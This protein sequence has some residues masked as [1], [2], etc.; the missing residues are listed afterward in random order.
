MPHHPKSPPVFPYSCASSWGEDQYGLWMSLDYYA[1]Q[2][3]FRWIEPGTFM[4]GSPD[5]EKG[6]Y[7]DEEHHEVTLSQGFWMAETTVTQALWDSVMES[8]PSHFKGE[9]LPVETV[10]WDDC[11]AFIKKMNEH[12]PELEIRLPWE[13]EW[14]Y[15]CRAGTETAFNFGS[16]ISL[17]QVNYRGVWELSL[18][19]DEKK[20]SE[21]AQ[22]QWGENALKKTSNVK[23]Y[24]CND[25][26]LYE[27]HGNVWEWCQ[28][29]WQD[30]LGK[31]TIIDPKHEE[32]E[33][34][35]GAMREIRGGSWYGSGRG[36]RSA[37]RNDVSPD[38]RNLDLGLRLSLGQPSGS[39]RGGS[40]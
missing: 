26:G 17:S 10:S 31:E 22:D 5:D 27:M 18:G 23:H 24:V 14:E 4:M 40:R 1:V 13:A 32:S 15:A 30:S 34:E 29:H 3:F 8:N 37:F 16:E 28:D 6:R 11:Q 35:E 36:A 33:P 21:E 39:S 9:D 19:K 12:H 20:W 25:W 7:D 38:F 2:M